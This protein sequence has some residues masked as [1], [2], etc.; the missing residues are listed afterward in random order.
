M[1][2]NFLN[3]NRL[4]KQGYRVVVGVDEVGRGAWAG[5][6]VAV[7]VFIENKNNIMKSDWYHWVQDS[8]KITART[9]ERV[10]Y[11]AIKEVKWALACTSSKEVDKLGVGKANIK[12]INKAVFNLKN[13]VDFVLADY[14]HKLGKTVAGVPVKA[15]V[16]GDESVFSIA[17]AS[18]IA[19]VKRDRMMKLFDKKYYGY[20]FAVNKGYGTK[21]HTVAL[22]K[23]GPCS[24]HRRS[25]RPIKGLPAILKNI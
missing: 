13:K 15:L 17:L 12:A 5:P 9:R 22:K 10:Y 25:Y 6:L 14:V 16:K 3:E 21:L 1:K 11:K 19:K 18:I 4:N 20:G 7:A 24:L 23:R 8:K 2:P